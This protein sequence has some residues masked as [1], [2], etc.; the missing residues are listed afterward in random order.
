[1]R[2]SW[3]V[4]ADTILQYYTSKKTLPKAAVLKLRDERIQ[5]LT[6]L[7]DSLR[8]A[9]GSEHEQTKL[10][11]QHLQQATSKKD[12]YSLFS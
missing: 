11:Q 9:R 3:Q 2:V 8:I 1:M 6:K 12:L 10:A 4:H 5:V 7:C